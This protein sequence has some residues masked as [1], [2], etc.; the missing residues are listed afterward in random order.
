MAGRPSTISYMIAPS[1]HRS[2]AGPTALATGLL[3]EVYDGL[4]RG[5]ERRWPPS[6]RSRRPRPRRAL[7][8]PHLAGAEVAVCDPFLMGRAQDVEDTEPIWDADQ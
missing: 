5:A 2:V 6:A 4:P 1:A 7:L 3:G 8:H